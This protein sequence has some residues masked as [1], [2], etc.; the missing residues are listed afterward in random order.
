MAL[1]IVAYIVYKRVQRQRF[2]ATLKTARI[3]ADELKVL[4]DG[5]HEPVILDVRIPLHIKAV[6]Y[7]VPGARRVSAEDLS[8]DG[9]ELPHAAEV[10]LYCS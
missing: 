8:R 6:P 4:L 7:M 1:V 10:V 2:L 3:T 5:G 9:D